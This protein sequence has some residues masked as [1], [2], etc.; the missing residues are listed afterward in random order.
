M[1]SKRGLEMAL[2]QKA[3]KMLLFLGAPIVLL[4]GVS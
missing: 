1:V 2:S 3:A 4:L